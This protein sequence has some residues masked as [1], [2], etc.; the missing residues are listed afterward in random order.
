MINHLTEDS[1]KQISNGLENYSVCHMVYLEEMF[2]GFLERSII[3]QLLERTKQR[4]LILSQELSELLT[5]SKL[6]S[7]NKKCIIH[8]NN[9][10]TDIKIIYMKNT[11]NKKNL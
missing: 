7:Y 4:R 6:H 10:H 2:L 11:L 9:I 3:Q 1:L 5:K 8:R